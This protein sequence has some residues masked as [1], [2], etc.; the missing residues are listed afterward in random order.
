MVTGENAISI[1]NSQYFRSDWAPTEFLLV[2]F[3]G[4][5]WKPPELGG[6]E[7]L[8]WSN[9]TYLMVSKYVHS[10]RSSRSTPGILDS[11]QVVANYQRQSS[12]VSPNIKPEDQN[13][14]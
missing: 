13:S 2:D 10:S 11:C 6:L 1:K 5:R 14:N 7:K 3:Q 12:K 8:K 9:S 4:I